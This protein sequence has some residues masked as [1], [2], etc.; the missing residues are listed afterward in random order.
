MERKTILVGVLAFG[1]VALTTLG[2]WL[3][4][5]AGG[6]RG[7][8]YA[9]PFPPAP[10]IN[11]LRNDGSPF[12][13]EDLRGN[14]VL[15]FFGYTS[16]PDVCPTTMAELKT[17]LENIGPEKADQVKVVFVTVDPQRDTPE[18]VQEYANH[19][20]QEFIGLSG[21]ESEL[22]RVWSDYGVY[23]SVAEGSP[24]TG[25]LVDHTARI[26][27]IDQAGS[28]RSSYGF[29]TPVEDIVHDLKLLLQ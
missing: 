19:F 12:K 14:L 7:T 9:E 28:L 2:V 26:T 15:L 29:E 5:P 13:L 20:H 6:L 23:R 1:L 17:A 10:A 16:C 8:V 11:L 21:Q 27:L 24:A 4:W 25:Y 22:A 3:F 18:R